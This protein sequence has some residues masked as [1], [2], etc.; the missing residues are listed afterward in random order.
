MKKTMIL[1]MLASVLIVAACQ[2]EA[3]TE[4]EAGTTVEAPLVL[5]STDKRL[6]YGI[7]FGLGGQLAADGVPLNVEAFTAGLSDAVA[8]NDPLMTQE[9]IAAEMQTYQQEQAERMQTEMAEAAGKNGTEGSV[10]LTENGTKEGVVTLESGLQYKVLEAG[11]GATPT[12]ADTVEVHYSGTLIDGT[13]FDSSYKRGETVKFGVTQVIGGWTEALQ[14][15]KVGA[16]WQLF[17][18]ADLAY[19][20]AGAGGIIGPNATLLFDVELVAIA[21]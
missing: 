3:V 9:E 13:E 5:D 7:A 18:P 15:M 10:F 17:I 19:G 12:S 2:Q 20:P 4:A 11:D 14:L 6:S 1:P 16:K 21:D 8:G